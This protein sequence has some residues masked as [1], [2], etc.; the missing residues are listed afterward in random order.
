MEPPFPGSVPNASQFIPLARAVLSLQSKGVCPYV[1]LEAMAA[2]IPVVATRV[3]G[4]P[5]V[6]DDGRSGVLVP[7]G[8]A[9]ALARSITRVVDDPEYASRLGEAARATVR[10]RFTADS[11]CQ[12]VRGCLRASDTG[13]VGA[14]RAG[15]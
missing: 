11:M 12:Q 5:E 15:L 9:H 7:H 1:L 10:T 6:I 2:G 8:D 4:I 3:G 14:T 13:P